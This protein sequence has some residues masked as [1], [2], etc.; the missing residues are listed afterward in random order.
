MHP[1]IDDYT[2]AERCG[3]SE[4]TA[5]RFRLKNFGINKKEKRKNAATKRV[6]W[7][8]LHVCWAIDTM[9]LE[10]KQGRVY[11]Q[12]II[13]ERSRQVIAFRLYPE[14]N[15]ELSAGLIKDTIKG[16]GLAPLLIKFDKGKEFNNEPV[17]E[18]LKENRVMPLI[19]PAHYPEFNGKIEWANRY[20]RE[21]FKNK[22]K[23]SADKMRKEIAEEIRYMNQQK[24]RKVLGG[25]TSDHIYGRERII[26][27]TERAELTDKIKGT[28][29]R[30]EKKKMK[31]SKKMGRLRKR[32]IRPLVNMGLLY[33]NN[34][35]PDHKQCEINIRKIKEQNDLKIDIMKGY[36]KY[37]P[38]ADVLDGIKADFSKSA[39]KKV[40]GRFKREMK[41]KRG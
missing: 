21:H 33:I 38:E 24:K 20:M 34:R 18:V 28:L 32:L 40:I 31:L 13:E 15:G 10:T 30:L 26:T 37:S 17:F 14:I 9:Y 12:M 3:M 25:K 4:S 11:L 2:L 16:L 5:R 1:G 39:A 35:L 22:G 23:M 36:D 6:I 19:S 8:A 41:K 27:E 29:R 7:T